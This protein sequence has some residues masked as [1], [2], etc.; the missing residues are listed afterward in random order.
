MVL[1]GVIFFAGL[2]FTLRQAYAPHTHA[3][4]TLICPTAPAGQG[5]QLQPCYPA[6]PAPTISEI[7][8]ITITILPPQ[9]Y[10]P[11][12]NRD[13]RRPVT[14]TSGSGTCSGNCCGRGE[15]GTRNGPGGSRRSCDSKPVI[16]LYTLQDTDVS[17]QVTIPGS[18]TES[19]PQYPAATGWQHIL[20]HPNG[21][22]DYQGKTYTELFYETL[23][24]KVTAP[25]AGFMIKKDETASTLHMLVTKLGF[26]PSEQQEFLNYWVPRLQQLPTPYVFIS[27]FSQQQKETIDQVTINP[28]PDTF[29]Q[30]IFF[31]KGMNT[32]APVPQLDLPAT[33]VQRI[34]FTALEWGGIVD[35][36]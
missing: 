19:I 35:T 11:P 4:Q 28:T 14:I 1:A 36:Y 16:Y 6:T 27:L 17:V 20:A 24:Q 8:G 9:D 26:L 22:L 25:T 29:L 3:D 33:P 30:Y 34:G 7:P 31:F 10:T 15:L 32:F 2:F 12:P 5:L 21:T 18:I 23:Q 13:V